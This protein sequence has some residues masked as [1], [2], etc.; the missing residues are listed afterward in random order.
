MSKEKKG[1]KLKKEKE[2]K[3]KK[4]GYVLS[5]HLSIHVT[6]CVT[7]LTFTTFCFP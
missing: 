2:K 3:K 5:Q 4:K 6:A 1:R 7:L